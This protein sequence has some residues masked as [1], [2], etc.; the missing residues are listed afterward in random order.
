MILTWGVYVTKFVTLSGFL[1]NIVAALNLSLPFNLYPLSRL[2]TMVPQK[3][4]LKSERENFFRNTSEVRDE[5]N[6]KR[7]SKLD[8]FLVIEIDFGT[9]LELDVKYPY[10]LILTKV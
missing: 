10:Q 9:M 3:V 6:K 1:F 4:K 5:I 7:Q 8:D 2:H